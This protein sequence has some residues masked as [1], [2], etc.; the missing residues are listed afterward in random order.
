MREKISDAESSLL[1]LL[2]IEYETVF[3][4]KSLAGTQVRARTGPIS[5]PVSTGNDSFIFIEVI[6]NTIAGFC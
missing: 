2:H 6:W 5:W 3:L 1:N 4:E